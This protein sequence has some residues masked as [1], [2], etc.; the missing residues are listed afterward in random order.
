MVLAG[1]TATL[2][3][4]IILGLLGGGGA[5]LTVPAMVY[6]FK[7]PPI[8]ATSYSLF[9]V[10]ASSLI[11]SLVY[12]R[13]QQIS[14]KTVALFSA[15]SILGVY[16]SRTFILPMLPEQIIKLNNF[17][18]S[19]NFLIMITFALLMISASYSMIKK[20]TQTNASTSAKDKSKMQI[21]FIG[22]AVGLL[23]GFVGAG[24]GFLIIPTLVKLLNLPI[25]TAI[26]SSLMII[27][28]QSLI[29]FTT[30]IFNGVVINWTLLFNISCISVMG[31]LIGSYLS[32]KI[33]DKKLKTAFGWLILLVGSTIFLEQISHL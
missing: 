28:L 12:L 1:Y 16:L 11:G 4:G 23:A 14:I 17:N 33:N 24:G 13:K 31:I 30:D 10:G 32:K 21:P 2:I 18:L 8:L 15:P 29:G 6:L 22:L 7:Q 27:A 19:K 20:E 3:I 26:G 5:V 25:K 9:I